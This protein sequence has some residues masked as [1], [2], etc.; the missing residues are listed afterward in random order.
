VNY[1]IQQPRAR[2]LARL[3]V[4]FACACMLAFS[5]VAA[6]Y[7]TA[8]AAPKAKRCDE[9]FGLTGTPARPGSLPWDRGVTTRPEHAWDDYL[10]DNPRQ[11][12]DGLTLPAD[13][14]KQKEILNKLDPDYTRYKEGT[15]ERVYAT[16]KKYLQQN[17]GTN[18]YGTFENWLN[19]S[20]IENY[21]INRRGDAFERKVVRDLG[22]VGPDWLCQEYIEVTGPDGKP[23]LRK[24]DAVNHKTKEFV[25]IKSG[26]NHDTSQRPKDRVIL[27]DPKYKDYKLRAVFG[28][29]QAKETRTAYGNLANEVGKDAQGRPRVTTY[30]HR[31]TAV[32]NYKP[33][34]Y[35]R[36]D[37]YMSTSTGSNQGS[38]GGGNNMINRS[39]PT[40]EDARRQI[41]RARAADPRG[42]RVRGPGGVDFTT[43]ELS[44]IATP[45][46]GRGLDYSF[47]AQ[48]A[49]EDTDPGWGGKEKAQLISDSMFTWLA[50]TPE[51][52]WVNLNPD[53]PNTIMDKR[54]GD[55]DAGRVL[56]QADL[57]MKHDYAKDMDPRGDLGEKYWEAMR[58][59][60]ISCGH[61]VRNW[62]VP[63]AAKVRVDEGGIYI[64]DAPL[65]VDSVPAFPKT[66]SPNGPCELTDSQRKTSQRLVNEIIIPDVER[67]VNT[68]PQYADLRRVY[69]ARVAAE[70]IRQQDQDHPTD[71][72]AIINSGDVHRW[73]L[74]GENKNWTPRQ[75]YNDYVKSYTKGDYSY[76]CEIN[77]Q[78]K[79]CVMGGVDFSKA[80][81]RNISRE[82][83][84]LEHRYLPRTTKTSVKAM[85]D[86]AENKY[87]LFLGGNTDGKIPGGG[88]QEPTPTPTHTSKPTASPSTQPASHTRTPGPSAQPTEQEPS[89][90]PGGRLANTGSHVLAIAGIAVA[91]LAAGAA[92]IWWGRR[93]T[94]GS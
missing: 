86:D 52:F 74:R 57:Q 31:T 24:Y 80:P 50:L 45:V 12:L 46:K 75:T 7:G 54:F 66:P 43:L 33:G 70:Y 2:A 88:A 44:Y 34:P 69:S 48:K 63:K 83:F 59:A 65:K 39:A 73:P 60:G 76:P 68:A 36:T 56:L 13:P 47:S 91:L 62:I 38:R 6:L 4:A 61:A 28:Q 93:R 18:K 15:P 67:K 27:N 78:Q 17:N 64:L 92:M 71:F 10:F 49:D 82:Q 90:S 85:T 16:F 87:T 42:M 11:A 25:E 29:E 84:T 20:Y 9:M 8:D 53:Q 5:G 81:K 26:G 79:T 22:L 94:A 89:A 21:A 3:A 14:A 51:K 35:T 30:E 37:P 58:A 23:V 40:P 55:T 72:H 19:E 41:E 1:L 77:G 32:P